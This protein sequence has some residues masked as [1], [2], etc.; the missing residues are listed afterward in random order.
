MTKALFNLPVLLAASFSLAATLV[1]S[2]LALADRPE[3]PTKLLPAKPVPAFVVTDH[4]GETLTNE[5]LLG[6]VWVC[7]FFLTR[8]N[9]ICPTLGLTMSGLADEFSKD[10]VFKDVRLISFSVDPEYDTVEQLQRYREI[11]LNAWGKGEEARRQAIQERWA[12]VRAEEQEP[13]WKLVREGFS[14][15]VGASPNDPQS[16]VSHS[17]RL[18]LIDQRGNIRGY[19]DGLSDAE[20]P[21]LMADIRRLIEETD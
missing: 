20:L 11:H 13:F 17:G 8:C 19:Y 9:A 18:V 4:H 21:A 10:Q 15:H 14:L 1:L 6:R 7:D 12:H 3:P 2:A 5:D 16:P